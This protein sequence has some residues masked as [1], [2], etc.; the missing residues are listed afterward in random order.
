MT[1]N[2]DNILDDNFQN[3]LFTRRRDLLPMWM[4]IFCWIFMI[5]GFT[6]PFGF[7]LGLLGMKFSLA[8]FGLETN[9]PFSIVGIILLVI[10]TLKGIAAFSL[11]TEKDWAIKIGRADAIVGIILCVFMMVIFPI[12]DQV[13]NSTL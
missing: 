5:M 3:K 10:F 6:L 1:E 4:K 11:W 7:I 9:E 2:T 13:P 12:F 8:F